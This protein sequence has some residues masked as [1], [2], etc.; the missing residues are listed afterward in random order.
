M[1]NKLLYNSCKATT[2]IL[3]LVVVPITAEL[4]FILS[5]WL[6]E[7]PPYAYALT[8]IALLSNLPSPMFSILNAGVHATG[9]NVRLSIGSGTIFLLNFPLTYLCY[10]LGAPYWTVMLIAGILIEAAIL[11]TA[12]TCYKQLPEFGLWSFLLKVVVPIHAL[13]L[14]A[15]LA[16]QQLIAAMPAGWGRLI[17]VGGLSSLLQIGLGYYFILTQEHRSFIKEKIT[18][19]TTR[20]TA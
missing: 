9:N 3:S 4:P 5:L 7:V 12:W 17:A 2:L 8:A 1:M 10:Q 15:L 13:A 18:R 20:K 14:L 6:K 19:W 16:C 11:F